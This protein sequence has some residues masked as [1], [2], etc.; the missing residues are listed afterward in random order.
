MTFYLKTFSLWLLL[1]PCLLLFNIGKVVVHFLIWV[2][3]LPTRVWILCM[4]LLS[5]FS[6]EDEEDEDESNI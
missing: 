2:F 5:E 4:A 1:F 6:E 3:D